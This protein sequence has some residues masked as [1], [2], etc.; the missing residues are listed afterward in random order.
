[1]PKR[2]DEEAVSRLTDDE[3]M[4]AAMNG[5]ELVPHPLDKRLRKFI[6]QLLTD[7]NNLEKRWSDINRETVN[8]LQEAQSVVDGLTE[9]NKNWQEKYDALLKDL[10]TAETNL[11]RA[12]DLGVTPLNVENYIRRLEDPE[13]LEFLADLVYRSMESEKMLKRARVDRSIVNSKSKFPTN[14]LKST[15]ENMKKDA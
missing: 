1:M 6:R 12:H 2:L 10:E 13:E 8:K 5:Q 15:I 9:T 4:H 14:D 3:I 7:Y 11:S